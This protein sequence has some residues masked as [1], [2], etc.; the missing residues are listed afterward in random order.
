[1][2]RESQSEPGMHT[3]SV[4]VDDKVRH[5]RVRNVKGGVALRENPE[6]REIFPSLLAL[7]RGYMAS[8]MQLHDTIPFHLL[9]D[10]GPPDNSEA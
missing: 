6:E 9:S 10:D 8:K 2:V 4:L 3:L 5:I 7:I 1:M